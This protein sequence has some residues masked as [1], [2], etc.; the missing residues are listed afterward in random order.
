MPENN[1]I[2]EV[3]KAGFTPISNEDWQFLEGCAR[4]VFR[5]D[6]PISEDH[7][8]AGR[9][10]QIRDLLN[11][12]YRE[13]RHAVL[14]GERGVGKTSLA[15]IVKNRIME[16]AKFIKVIK[17]SCDPKDDFAGIWSKVFFDYKWEVAC[18]PFSRHS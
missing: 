6:A 10:L 8:F 18:S 16:P 5:P 2:M 14:Y 15:N 13:G 3:L 7:L 12:M 11:A 17:I 1:G 4:A 9:I